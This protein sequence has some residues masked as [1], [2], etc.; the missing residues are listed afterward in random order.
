MMVLKSISLL[1]KQCNQNLYL[2]EIL[3]LTYGIADNF[4][5]HPYSRVPKL[6]MPV[7][8]CIGILKNYFISNMSNGL[9]VCKVQ[10]SLE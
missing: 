6:I 7:L 3:S 4:S 2:G 10:S 9:Y 8:E 5:H 1:H